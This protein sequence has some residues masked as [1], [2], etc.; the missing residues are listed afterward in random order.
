MSEFQ[1]HGR[2]WKI[3]AN[4]PGAT[5]LLDVFGTSLY[6]NYLSQNLLTNSLKFTTH[7]S[8]KLSV[9]VLSEDRDTTKIAFTVTDSGIGIEEDVRKKLFKPFSQADSS[10]ARRFGGTG[11]G[12]TISK[13]LV[14]LMHGE[15]ELQSQIG[16]G[17]TARFWLPFRK[18]HNDTEGEALID[19]T[20]IPD[21]LQ[22]EVSVSWNSDADRTPPGTPPTG[23]K[24]EVGM[25][26]DISRVAARTS[27]ESLI[28]SP[29]SRSL[30]NVLVV[31][32]TSVATRY[33]M[34]D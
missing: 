20:S 27:E 15:I 18:V 9:S 4:H 22:S 30:I 21:R 3:E 34:V 19:L 7:G 32:G 25:R 16:N 26:S 23:T 13:N 31:E 28:L 14:E 11:L 6:T 17:T 29:E 2:P 33:V 12:L 24:T 1:G 5:M 8:I 10:T